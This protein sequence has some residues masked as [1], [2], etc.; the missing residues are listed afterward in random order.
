MI[1]LMF[2]GM[3]RGLGLVPAPDV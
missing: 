2:F 1:V 3:T